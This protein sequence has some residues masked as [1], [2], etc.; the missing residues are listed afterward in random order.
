[1]ITWK[2]ERPPAPPVHYHFADQEGWYNGTFT[3]EE[4][5]RLAARY[6]RMDLRC[7]YKPCEE[8]H[9]R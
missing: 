1:M 7:E 2:L 5:Q 6:E 8:H 9:P 4:V 3:L